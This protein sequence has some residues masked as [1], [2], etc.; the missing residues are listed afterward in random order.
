MSRR[1]IGRFVERE[2]LKVALGQHR[3]ASTRD[4]GVYR[5]F[6]EE[7]EKGVKDRR[8]KRRRKRRKDQGIRA[9]N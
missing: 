3:S 8:R 4:A 9:D 7:K 1:D 2:S 6:C 5:L